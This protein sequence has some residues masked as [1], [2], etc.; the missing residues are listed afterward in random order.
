MGCRTHFK[1]LMLRYH[2]FRWPDP[3][4]EEQFFQLPDNTA[5]CCDGTPCE[6]TAMCREAGTLCAT[7]TATNTSK[8][9]QCP[10]CDPSCLGVLH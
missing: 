4:A 5:L 1:P 8:V 10:V 6:D 7:D 3:S 9:I 2:T